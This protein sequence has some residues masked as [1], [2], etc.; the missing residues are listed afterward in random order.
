MPNDSQRQ[1]KKRS[2]SWPGVVMIIVAAAAIPVSIVSV[3]AKGG[4]PWSAMIL[5]I[6]IGGFA[7]AASRSNH[8]RRDRDGEDSETSSQEVADLRKRVET[9]ERIVTSRRYNLDREFDALDEDRN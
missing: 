3:A 2:E 8:H 6:A 5:L 7:Y 1:R 4:V 9:L